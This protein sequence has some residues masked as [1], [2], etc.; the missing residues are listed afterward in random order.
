M[1]FNVIYL[2]EILRFMDLGQYSVSAAQPGV[3]VERLNILKIAYPSIEEQDKIAEVIK[4][5]TDRFDKLTE[6]CTRAIQILQERR[7][8]LISAAVT[9]KIDVRDWQAPDGENSASLN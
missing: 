6:R 4:N 1:E 7:T 8:A 3:S 9:G 5:Q 2:A